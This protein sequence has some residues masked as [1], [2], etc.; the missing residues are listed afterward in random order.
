MI[1]FLKDVDKS[2]AGLYKV[3]ATND[4]G[5]VET[6]GTLLVKTPPK[7]KKK[8]ADMACMTDQPFKMQVELEGSPVPELKWYSSRQ[9]CL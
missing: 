5:T 3:V 4:L 9:N 1:C 7:F 2:D 6:Q 8:M